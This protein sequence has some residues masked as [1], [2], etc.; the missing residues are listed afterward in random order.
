MSLTSFS[1]LVTVF[2]GRTAPEPGTLVG[3][4]ALIEALQLAV[5][6]PRDVALISTKRRQYHVTGWRVFTPRHQPADTLW[7]HLVFALKYEGL[8][9]LF[10]K[11][12]FVQL[13]AATMEGLRARGHELRVLDAWT[14]AVGG[15]HGVAIDP[16]SG[17]MSG[18]ADPRRD[19][20]AIGW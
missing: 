16:S 6:L 7:A 20:A 10:F 18:G 11:K 9:L 2:H 8:D 15:G 13:P 5:P 3:Y 17:L 4:G 19:G 1:R 14:S 12:L